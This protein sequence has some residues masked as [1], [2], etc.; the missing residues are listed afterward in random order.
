MRR[1]V[2][3]G[4]VGARG[5]DVLEREVGAGLLEGEIGAEVVR[6]GVRRAC[7]LERERCVR[8][9]VLVDMVVPRR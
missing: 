9:R 4:G 8:R 2:P 3:A 1:W 7:A 6:I 5:A